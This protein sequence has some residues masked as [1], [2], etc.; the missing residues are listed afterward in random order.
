MG[1]A[2]PCPYV[3][4][5]GISTPCPAQRGSLQF[6]GRHQFFAKEICFMMPENARH[7]ETRVTIIHFGEFTANVR[8]YLDFVVNRC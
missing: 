5:R 1:V 2:P 6:V 8:N 4:M 3:M 7:E